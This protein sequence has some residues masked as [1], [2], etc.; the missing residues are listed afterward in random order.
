M[1]ELE[2]N[3]RS[4]TST[5]RREEVLE[6]LRAGM[7]ERKIA[8]DLGLERHSVAEIVAGLREEGALPREESS[9]S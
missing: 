7:S 1:T 6:R 3:Y 2:G 4:G 5:K 8:T 9:G